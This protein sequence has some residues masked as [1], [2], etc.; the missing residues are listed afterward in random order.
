MASMAIPTLHQSLTPD[1]ARKRP[2]APAATV[3][4]TVMAC[5]TIIKLDQ[6]T[7]ELTDQTQ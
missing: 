1:S 4:T 5:L 2:K 7:I 6:Q 3:F